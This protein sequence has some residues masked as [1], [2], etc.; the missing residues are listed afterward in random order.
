MLKKIYNTIFIV[1]FLAV[2]AVPLVLTDWSSGG[3]SEEENRNLAKFPEFTKEGQWNETF[4]GEFETW[5]MDHLG[6][7]QELITANALLQFKGFDRMLSQ[8]D[9]HIGPYGDINYATEDMI[10]DYAHVNLW[11]ET[12]VGN[13]GQSYQTV[14]DWLAE[15]GIPFYYIQ[16]YDKHSVYPEQFTDAVRQIGDVS[17]TDQ[18]LS[19][20]ENNTTVAAISLKQPLLDAKA[21]YEVYSNWGDPSHWTDRG[22][23]V[24]YLHI[25]DRLNQD[26]QTPLKVLQESDYDITVENVGI[27]LNRVIHED[28]FVEV[29]KIRDPQAQQADNSVMGKWQDQYHTV[30]K[31]PNAGND[32]KLLLLCDSYFNSYLV[33]DFA[34]SF[35]EVWVIWAD[36]MEELPQMLEIY[37]ADMV[38]IECA[39]RVDRNYNMYNLA[40]ALAD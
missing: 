38:I 15:K 16:C 5:F 1:L 37:D 12:S 25:M 23:Y 40:Q 39:E 21:Q 33:D 30:W 14:S 29:F 24:G 8:S 2:L 22:A 4:T 10:L 13:L 35:S 28:D 32:L 26:R 19:Y 6:L 27:T 11:K 36:H 18:I 7:R 17:K 20:L 31:N 9:Y 3:V 34:E